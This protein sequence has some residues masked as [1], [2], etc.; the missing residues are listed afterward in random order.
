MDFFCCILALLSLCP[1][2]CLSWEKLNWDSQQ[3]RDLATSG[4]NKK[5]SIGPILFLFYEESL[6][7][8]NL[9]SKLFRFYCVRPNLH[10][11][12]A[13][14]RVGYNGASSPSGNLLQ[15]NESNFTSKVPLRLWHLLPT[16]FASWLSKET[17]MLQL[18]M[19][20]L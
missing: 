4:R 12:F 1:V 5:N 16:L 19:H 14:S 2:G 18:F 8:S 13:Y 11:Y 6:V 15:S 10:T 3:G 20:L 7:S 17:Q 9:N